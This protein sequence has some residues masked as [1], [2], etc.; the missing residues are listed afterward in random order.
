MTL[1]QSLA[2]VDAIVVVSDYM[3]SLLRDAVPHVDG[4][5]HLLTRPIRDLGD[6]R[7]AT[8]PDPTIQPSSPTPGGSPRRRGS[9]S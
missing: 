7:L 1:S 8:A 3:R 2:E 5:L 9:P 6:L 4:R